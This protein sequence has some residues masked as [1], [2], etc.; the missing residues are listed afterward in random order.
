MIVVDHEPHGWFLLQDRAGYILDVNC[1]QCFVSFFVVLRLTPDES[2][3]VHSE[4]HSAAHELARSIQHSPATYHSRHSGPEL[5][6]STLAAIKR[7]Q[8]NRPAA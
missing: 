7:W 8:A 6:A 2:A 4:G 3:L 5:E 1:S